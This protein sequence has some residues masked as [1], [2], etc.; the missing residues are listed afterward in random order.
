[1]NFGAF[2][3]SLTRLYSTSSIEGLTAGESQLY[4]KLQKAFDPI[5]LRVADVSGGCG[6]MYAIDIASKSFEGKSIVKQHRLVNDLLK[7]EIKD[8]HGLQL[9]TSSK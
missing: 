2:A 1:M 9:R 8:M 7:E 6:S 4:N 3:R 5:R